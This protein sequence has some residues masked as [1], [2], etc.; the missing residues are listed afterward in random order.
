MSITETVLHFAA[1]ANSK[2]QFLKTNPT[3]FLVAS[4]MSGAY[5][6]LGILLIFS[7]G[8]TVPTEFK[9]VLMGASFGIA[10]TL[11]M[12]AGSELFT[13][14]TMFFTFGKLTGA[15][16][17]LDVTKSWIVTWFGNLSGAMLLAYLF[18][19]GGGGNI[20]PGDSNSLLSIV[21]LKKSLLCQ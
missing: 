16:S 9:T 6:G 18:V 12:F 3:G 21:A 14:H 7:I 20:I 11:V 13:G 8:Q 1:L 15:S 5:V 2:S 17:F 10:L 4:L 19:I